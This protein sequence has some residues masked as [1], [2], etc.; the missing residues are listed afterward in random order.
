MD[1]VTKKAAATIEKL[2]RLAGN[3][4][5]PHQAAEA[6]QKAND[7]MLAYNLNVAVIEQMSGQSGKRTDEMVR[8]GMHKYQ[9]ELW[10]HIS[11]LNFCMYWTQKNRVGG[12]T[13]RPPRYKGH[14]FVHEHRLV[15]RE[16]NV[17]ATRNM[18]LYLVGTINR[19]CEEKFLTTNYFKLTSSDAMA[20]R[21][22]IADR[23]IQKIVER[24]EGVVKKERAEA[25]KAAREAA[26]R[27]I[28]LATAVTVTGVTES[29]KIA[30]YDFIHG[31][32][33][34]ARREARAAEREA[35]WDKE[36]AAQAKADREAEAA[37]ARWAAANPEEAA[38]EAKK[39]AA[40]QRAA[41]RR[42]ANRSYSGRYSFRETKE[43][44]R[45]SSPS[46]H[47]GYEKGRSVSIDPQMDK[48]NQR[49]I[50]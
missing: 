9:R 36:R 13:G 5:N 46:Y 35:N 10:Q 16:V 45:R 23:V 11:S 27:G 38:R 2:M 26:A 44:L 6:L 49:K 12:N 50:K 7:M 19:L 32:G 20:Y 24:R 34:W 43:D 41:D 8:G 28:S 4:D 21:E 31:Q 48:D 47:D 1:E 42:S 39:E 30:N 37:Y 25:A 33:A 22:G 18:A 40:K 17:I 3:N 14:Q 29:E 15:G